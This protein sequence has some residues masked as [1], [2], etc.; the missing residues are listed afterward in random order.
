[1][2]VPNDIEPCPICGGSDY[3]MMETRSLDCK[4]NSYYFVCRD[5]GF[6][7]GLF[8]GTQSECIEKYNEKVRLLRKDLDNGMD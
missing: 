4:G 5:C 8:R 3:G 7:A 6:H 1:M 2:E